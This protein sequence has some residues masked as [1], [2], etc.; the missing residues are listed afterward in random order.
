MNIF[1]VNTTPYEEE[2]FYLHTE[3]DEED[4]VEIITPI[5]NREREGSYEYDNEVLLD[6]IKKRY[7]RK[8]IELYTEFQ[9]IKI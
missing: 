2:D 5:V 1:R 7:P 4:I 6:A 3:L 9:L 8:K